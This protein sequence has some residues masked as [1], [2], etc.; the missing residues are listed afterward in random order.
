MVAK[1]K[2]DFSRILSHVIKMFKEK[3]LFFKANIKT[4]EKMLSVMVLTSKGKMLRDL[5]LVNQIKL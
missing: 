4:M 3:F 5:S 2:A 1:G